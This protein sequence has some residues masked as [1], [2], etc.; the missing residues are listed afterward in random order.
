MISKEAIQEEVTK[1]AGTPN[2][3]Y[4]YHK[5]GGLGDDSSKD[6]RDKARGAQN[7]SPMKE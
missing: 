4:Q 2:R 3:L 7:I 1:V 5:H 6:T